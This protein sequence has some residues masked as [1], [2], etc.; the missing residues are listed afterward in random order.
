[1]RKN[2]KDEEWDCEVV[3]CGYYYPEVRINYKPN[4]NKKMD[5]V[6]VIAKNQLNKFYKL[7]NSEGGDSIYFNNKEITM[8][9]SHINNKCLYCDDITLY[10]LQVDNRQKYMC[11][12]CQ[13]N[14][15]LHLKDDYANIN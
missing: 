1:M 14:V 6:I 8:K 13:V 10:Y 15:L 9:K 4:K 12:D 7:L 2:N 3:E 5:T 11:I